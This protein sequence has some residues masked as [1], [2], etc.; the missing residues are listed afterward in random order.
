MIWYVGH[1]CFLLGILNAIKWFHLDRFPIRATLAPLLA[2]SFTCSLLT[3]H[4]TLITAHF[5]RQDYTCIVIGLGG[6]GSAAAYWL[7]RRLGADL[8][9][10]EQY[11]LGH[12]RGGSHDHSRIIRLSYHTPEYVTLAKQAYRAWEMLEA[13]AGEPL[14][15]RTGSLDLFPAGGYIPLTTY[16]DSMDAAAVPYERL[17]AAEM[18]RYWPQ[19]HLTDDVQ[20]LFQSDGG[21]VAAARATAAH[22]RVARD[23][24]AILHDNTLVTAIR[25]AHDIIEV[26]TPAHTFHC[27]KLIIASGA[28][29][30]HHLAHL[31]HQINL[32]VTQEQVNYFASPHREQFTPDRFPVWIW[33]DSP[34]FYGFPLYG[35]EAV[36]V[37]Q[38]VG[39]DEVTVEN[40]T[41]EPNLATLQR[42]MDFMARVLPSACGPLHYSK[43]CL[44][45]MPPDRDFV[46][47]TLPGYPNIA[48]AI[49]AGHAFKFASL[50]GLLLSE[51]ALDGNA[52]AANLTPFSFTRPILHEANPVKEFMI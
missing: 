22:Q 49:G 45:A 48:V 26:E 17:S 32:T 14:V 43:T 39:G 2:C 4:C 52:A 42:T 28:W 11:E 19:F 21:F 37:N 40:R 1:V 33:M 30:N 15:F 36:K 29:A 12:L 50:F 13:E 20:G 23:N 47:D 31:G 10:L 25:P 8:L 27:Q 34:C 35:E 7:S 6:I 38:D 9:G 3:L 16:T 44:Y 41:F 24:G 51:I 5:M 18:M 46:L